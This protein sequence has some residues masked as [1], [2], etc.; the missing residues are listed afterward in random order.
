M[1]SDLMRATRSRLLDFLPWR[2]EEIMFLRQGRQGSIL[3]IVF[4]FFMVHC[5]GSSSDAAKKL[6]VAPQ[7]APQFYST[8]TEA[9]PSKDIPFID[10]DLDF[11]GLDLALDRQI[12][13]LLERNLNGSTIT[14][15]SKTYP[16]TTMLSSLRTYKQIILEYRKCLSKQSRN[17]CLQELNSLIKNAFDFYR[18][19]LSP[20]DPRFGDPQPALFTAYYTPTMLVQSTPNS[21]YKY[22]IYKIPTN[23]SLAQ[24]SR[25]EIDFQGKLKNDSSLMFYAKDLFDLYLMQ[26][27]G[28]GKL[29][30]IDKPGQPFQYLSYAG[31]N[32]KDFKFISIYMQEKGYIQDPSIVSQRK[33]LITNPNKQREIFSY[34]PGY[35]FFQPTATPPLGSDKV[36]LTDN[37]SLATDSNHFR[38]KGL[39]SFVQSRRPQL[40]SP[41]NQH[42]G[43][44]PTSSMVPAPLEFKR[45]FIDQDTGG[46]IKGKARADLYFGEDTYAEFVSYNL[47]EQ[48]RIY[49]LMEK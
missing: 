1:R 8:P 10:D 18:P 32:K 34:S 20:K 38:M 21:E 13:R 42:H 47:K 43:I 6:S 27:Q 9:V 17:M 29:K 49:F 23:P 37:R 7:D 33:F 39:I 3:I 22:G 45:F 11:A 25:D 44:L 28:G 30:I 46:A 14:L 16:L 26:V 48:G 40:P 24:L 15:G 41:T 35:V 31:T 2:N 5:S 36:A 19:L 4:A 12:N